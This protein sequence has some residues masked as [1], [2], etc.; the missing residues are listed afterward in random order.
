LIVGSAS[1]TGINDRT[2]NNIASLVLGSLSVAAATPYH[3][4][5]A[6]LRPNIAP[7]AANL[8]LRGAMLRTPSK[9]DAARF[10]TKPVD[11]IAFRSYKKRVVLAV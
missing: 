4:D 5:S 2:S 8:V 3:W 7:Q 9:Q 6:R 10:Y 11:E 1:K